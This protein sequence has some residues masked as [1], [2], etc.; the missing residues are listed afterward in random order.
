MAAFRFEAADAAGLLERGVIDADSA[1]HARSLLRERA[2]VPLEVTPV[3]AAAAGT[4]ALPGGRL[5]SAD[6]TL[7]TRQLASLLAARLTLEQANASGALSDYIMLRRE[8]SLD[9]YRQTI[10]RATTLLDQ[11]RDDLAD[12]PEH[13]AKIAELTALLTKE[14]A[15]YADTFPL[16]VANSKPAE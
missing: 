5:R 8:A 7:A 15:S 13:A 3:G 10:G 16:T 4:V 6:L 2:L 11:L 9:D 12:D 14:M 1:R